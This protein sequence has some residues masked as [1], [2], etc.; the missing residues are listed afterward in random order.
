[1]GVLANS[2]VAPAHW[3]DVR[4]AAALGW[5]IAWTTASATLATDRCNLGALPSL[6]L[7]AWLADIP[8]RP[9]R[10]TLAQWQAQVL[11]WL[12]D[13][14]ALSAWLWSRLAQFMYDRGHFVLRSLV[15]HPVELAALR[16][17][18]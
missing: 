18:G 6:G 4:T 10:M 2:L 9:A 17:R 3:I 16:V 1:M 11:R 15:A 5:S 14:L 8:L 7:A 12:D 13:D